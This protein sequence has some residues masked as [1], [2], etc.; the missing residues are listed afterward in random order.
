MYNYKSSPQIVEYTL[1]ARCKSR[2]RLFKKPQQLNAQESV[3][4]SGKVTV[5]KYKSQSSLNSFKDQ[6]T[7]LGTYVSLFNSYNLAKFQK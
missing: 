3:L 6:D 1:T 7:K 5:G 2:S 4:L